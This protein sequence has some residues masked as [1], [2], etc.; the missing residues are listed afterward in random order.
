[1]SQKIYTFCD[2]NIP[3]NSLSGI[4]TWDVYLGGFSRTRDISWDIS[5]NLLTL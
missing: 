1:M 2:I 4:S 3:N 5:Y